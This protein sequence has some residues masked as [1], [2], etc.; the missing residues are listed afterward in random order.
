MSGPSIQALLDDIIRS[1]GGSERFG[2]VDHAIG[3]QLATLLASP[4]SDP[5]KHAQ[6]LSSLA[7]LLPPRVEAPVRELDLTRL[8]DR[9]LHQ[10]HKLV[11][12][13]EGAHFRGSIDMQHKGAKAGE[14]KPAEH[15]PASSTPHVGSN[16][17]PTPAG[18]TR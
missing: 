17:S 15:K 14:V 1:H 5:A 13:A 6:A 2:P 11:A 16:V 9:Q 3:F 18:I 8:T 10:L 12:I 4:S 7:A